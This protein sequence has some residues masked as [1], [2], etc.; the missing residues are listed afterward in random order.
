MLLGL[1]VMNN[2]EKSFLALL[3]AGLWEQSVSLLSH[4]KVDFSVV[5]EIAE[6][7]S[8][9]GLVS[10]GIEHV[11]DIKVP[12]N[13]ALRFIGTTLQMEQRS[14]AMNN[15]IKILITRLMSSGLEA[16]LVK[17]QGIAQCYERP[18]SSACGDID[19]LL[20]KKN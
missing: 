12:Q 7:Q 10:A 17:G 1:L 19:L 2:S 14:A 15:F 8:V 18:L 20:D 3:R 6:D 13:C 5:Y 9:I 11:T 4:G 16:V